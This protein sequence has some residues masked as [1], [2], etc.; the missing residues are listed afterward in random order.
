MLL[1]II[2]ETFMLVIIWN[3]QIVTF[4][5]KEWQEFK[6]EYSAADSPDF[7]PIIP[8]LISMVSDNR[9]WLLWNRNGQ[10][11]EIEA[12]LFLILPNIRLFT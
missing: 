8:D 1:I 12:G 2:R 6:S 3:N 9:V 4:E 7:T 11:A 5:T 10:L